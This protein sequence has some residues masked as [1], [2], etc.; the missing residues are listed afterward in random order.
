ML[1]LVFAVIG[2]VAAYLLRNVSR[3]RKIAFGVAAV[4][5]YSLAFALI[6][7]AV[8]Q[9]TDIDERIGLIILRNLLLTMVG[10][11]T[12]GLMSYKRT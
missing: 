9:S 6:S 2:G 12:V 3:K 1:F 7:S 8:E 11:F 4:A 5:I 10:V